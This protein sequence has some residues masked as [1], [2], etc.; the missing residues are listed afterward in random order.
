[1]SLSL[2]VAARELR[3]GIRGFRIFLLCLMLGVAAI[4][5]VGLV[6]GAI[7]RGLADQ[8]AVLL[9]G[10]AQYEFTY[11][12]ATAAER[13]WIAAD[14][15]AVSEVIDFRSMASVGDERALAQVKAV[16]GA[17]PLVGTLTLDPPVGMGALAGQD[18]L[19]GAFVDPVLADRL[20]LSPGD[21][22]QV[23][24]LDVV[25]MARIV[26][27][28]DSTGFGISFGPRIILG[29]S[30][31]EG[32]GLLAPGALYESEYRVLLPEGR[33]LA[34]A[35]AAALAHFEGA[36][37]R[38]SDSRRASPSAERFV[39]QLGSFLV[40]VGLAGLAVGGTGISATVSA[41]IERK[42][43]TI[44]TLKALGATTATIRAVFLWQLGAISVAGIAASCHR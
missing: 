13:D 17:Y 21:R 16:D 39:N 36:G 19:P 1:M 15:R 3:G 34:A 18:G 27:E 30:A 28:P 29:L 20:E 31:V 9:G 26:R 43:E 7:Q 2:R 42:A 23:G 32:T 41:W 37:L 24:G 5:A 40:L 4:A 35:R 22:L 10:D 25:M 12:R 33:D 11:R 44:A 6:R 38:W 14:A 8:G